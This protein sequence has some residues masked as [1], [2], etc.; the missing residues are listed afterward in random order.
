MPA[1]RLP[2]AQVDILASVFALGSEI[3]CHG[4]IGAV[5]KPLAAMAPDLANLIKHDPDP[6]VRSAAA[7]ALANINP[8][9]QVAAAPLVPHAPEAERR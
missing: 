5:L 4:D 8:P 7:Q 2:R 6:A 1:P 9:P 3:G